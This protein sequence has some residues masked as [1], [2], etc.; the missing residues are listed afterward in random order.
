MLFYGKRT[1]FVAKLP[2]VFGV[3]IWPAVVHP[4]LQRHWGTAFITAL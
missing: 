4:F 3:S 2:A 1:V